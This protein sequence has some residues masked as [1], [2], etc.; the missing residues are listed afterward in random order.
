MVAGRIWWTS[1]QKVR[2]IFGIG[3]GSPVQAA[4]GSMQ[5]ERIRFYDEVLK[6][7]QLKIWAL[8]APTLKMYHRFRVR[9]VVAIICRNL[10]KHEAS[11][12]FRRRV[13]TMRFLRFDACWIGLREHPLI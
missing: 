2:I 3:N 4:H 11:N 9:I 12:S 5:N 8:E 13:G 1:R 10:E 6:S 7:A